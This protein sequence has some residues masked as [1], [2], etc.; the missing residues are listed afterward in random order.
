[1]GNE[2]IDIAVKLGC[3]L[4][5]GSLIGLERTFHGRPAG[6]MPSTSCGFPGTKHLRKRRCGGG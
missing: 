3:A 2:Y 6:S 5:A 1:M 4:A